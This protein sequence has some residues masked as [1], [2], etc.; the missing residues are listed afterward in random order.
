[1]RDYCVDIHSVQFPSGNFQAFSPSTASISGDCDGR[2]QTRAQVGVSRERGL[3]RE[4]GEGRLPPPTP[5]KVCRRLDYRL[6]TS[7][8]TL[9]I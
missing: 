8:L 2:S 5:A 9:L 3:Q 6:A 1:M 7:G 4:D